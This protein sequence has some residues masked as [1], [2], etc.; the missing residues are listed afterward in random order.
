MRN[1]REDAEMIQSVLPRPRHIRQLMAL[2]ALLSLMAP[3]A[4]A[5]PRHADDTVMTVDH[6]SPGTTGT[7]R[8]AGPLVPPRSDETVITFDGPPAPAPGSD[9]S[10]QY[11]RMGVDFTEEGNNGGVLPRVLEVGAQAHSG[12]RV[13]AVGCGKEFC[14]SSIVG[15]FTTTHARVE[16]WVGNYLDASAHSRVTLFA[17][18]PS[19][20]I[21]GR[22]AASVTGGAGFGTPL[23]VTSSA[24][25]IAS[26]VV[27]SE[28]RPQGG[29]ST[30]IGIDDLTFD[31]SAVPPPPDF[32]LEY[33]AAAHPFGGLVDPGGSAAVSLVIHRVNGS[34]G[35]LKL[36]VSGLP[37]GVSAA[38]AE[39]PTS[40]GEGAVVGLTFTADATAPGVSDV[41]VTVTG[42]PLDASAGTASHT[43]DIL[44]T[45]RAAF[46]VRVTGIE[47]TQGIQYDLNNVP[48]EAPPLAPP[49]D[50]GLP[51]RNWSD[52]TAAV[53]Y[54]GVGLAAGK[55]T[56]VRV[57]ADAAAAPA[58]GK[59]RDVEATLV[60]A[61][62]DGTPLPGSPLLP[63]L[64]TRD[65]SPGPSYTTM[66]ERIVPNGGYIFTLPASWARGRITLTAE[67]YP[68]TGFASPLI[69]CDTAAC[70]DAKV[71]RLRDIAFTPTRTYEVSPFQALIAGEA[72]LPSP[73]LVYNATQTVMPL[74]DGNLLLPTGSSCYSV[75]HP[76]ATVS[77]AP[78]FS[79]ECATG[80]S[81]Y[82]GTLDVSDIAADS[83]GRNGKSEDVWDRLRDHENDQA[84]Y[85]DA[86]VAV[87]T[88]AGN[89]GGSTD[90]G[91]T[92]YREDK[93]IEVIDTFP[94]L[95][96]AG[97]PT[98]GRPLTAAAHEFGH[99]LGLAHA[100]KDCGGNDNGQTGVDWPPDGRGYIQ[101]IGL[102]PR[103]GAPYRIL[104]PGGAPSRKPY[105]DKQWYDFM[106]YC[107]SPGGDPNAWI[108]TRNWNALLA[109][110]ASGPAGSIAPHARVVAAPSRAPS[111]PMLDVFGDVT[112]SGAVELDRVH[113]AS[114]PLGRSGRRSPYQ[115]VVR[116]AVGKV[117]ASATMMV[118]SGH[119][120]EGRVFGSLVAR[121]PA[122][123]AMR[124]A[125]V[126]RGVVLAS[127][128]RS[129]HAPT[130]TIL[131]PQPGTT[132]GQ[133]AVLI[134]WQSGPRTLGGPPRLAYVDYSRDDGRTWRNIYL[135]PDR[136]RALLPGAYFAHARRG[137]VRVRVND[138]FNEAAAV[139]GRVMATGWPPSVQLVSPADGARIDD[140][141]ALYLSGQAYDDT[142]HALRGGHLRWYA[143]GQLV[144]TGNTAGVSGLPPGRATIRLVATDDLGRQA[145][146][147]VV[148]HVLGTVPRF[149]VLEAPAALSPRAT[150]LR[151]GVAT[152]LPAILTV[153]R[154]RYSVGRTRVVVVVPAPTGSAPVVLRLRLTAFGHYNTI[155]LL[156]I[157]RRGSAWT[158]RNRNSDAC[159]GRGAHGHRCAHG[160][161]CDHHPA[162]GSGH[163]DR[164]AD[165]SARGDALP[166][167]HRRRDGHSDADSDGHSDA[168]S[169]GHSDADSDGHSDATGD[170][171]EA[172]RRR[173]SSSG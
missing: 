101:G 33:N 170:P 119:V 8:M 87:V 60:G 77:G 12:T 124:V 13:A 81:Y 141:A 147:Q 5:T 57:F 71:F 138:G 45:V 73:S 36:A 35:P 9:I 63:D 54:G 144:G 108:S 91:D 157:P 116:N 100:S 64:G 86:S 28:G 46:A 66:A 84:D 44:V 68:S 89:I 129:R 169:D 38:F 41:P 114:G 11:H 67:I 156:R 137:R 49:D 69:E 72:P 56:I 75:Y 43:V 173:E 155:T 172:C 136:D 37:A 92:T 117:M 123:G 165:V 154:A 104:A 151:L 6:K 160:R 78:S 83:D 85:G 134:V 149:L 97:K 93:P 52:P 127:L 17:L 99:G 80:P 94:G 145:A 112:A 20:K 19:G 70:R 162:L 26:F 98:I 1:Q 126:R 88:G 2:I 125:I 121:V 148:V 74:A 166:D 76:P 106:S 18:D 61:A 152:T 16:V 32:G 158:G 62:A 24:R 171:A 161:R 107:A 159:A 58:D 105:Y 7:T 132:V 146:V 10:T 82:Q 47:V 103:G 167:H 25:E 131:S 15:L 110:F 23:E 34:T 14:A 142:S 133:G 22:D 115:L 65:L 118:W 128:T 122:S 40:G 29:P 164:T 21:I 90:Y 168:D 55:K 143:D 135:G 113:P 120:D 42:T 102:D 39:N 111:P 53:G 95:D 96:A 139:S 150:A 153:N 48:G 3:F 4:P 50:A 27:A 109:A 51:S 140:D 31:E 130:V 163:A 79:T 30:H 59:V